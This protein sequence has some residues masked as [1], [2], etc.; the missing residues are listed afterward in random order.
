MLRG[1]VIQSTR[2]HLADAETEVAMA[3]VDE[4]TAHLRYQDVVSKAAEGDGQR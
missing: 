4:A 3:D 1:L 2:A